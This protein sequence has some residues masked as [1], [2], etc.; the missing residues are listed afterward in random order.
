[1][2]KV[3]GEDLDFVFT[4]LRKKGCRRVIVDGKSVDIAAQFELDESAVQHMDAVVDRFVVDRKHEKAIKAG[5]AAAL[6]VGDG[7]IQV[8]VLAG[9]SKADADRFYRGLS[10]ATHHLV[11][12]EIG[13]SYFVF[14]DP[15]SACRT[16][17]GLG[18]DKV[19]HPELLDSRS[20]AQHPRR[21]LREGGVQVQPRHVGRPRDVQPVEEPRLLARHAVEGSEGARQAGRALRHRPEEGRA[22]LA[23]RGQGQARRSRRQGSRL[24]RHRPAHRALLPA[25]SPARRG[26]LADGGVARQGDGRAHLPGLQGRPAAR[27][28]SAV[29]DRGEDTSTRSGS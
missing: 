4:E 3:Y 6:L 10:S 9:A 28:A 26:Q 20:A 29:H 23:A 19:T 21:L 27:D 17:G 11:Y 25:L 8:H 12:G 2:F 14:N 24:Q 7:L 13:P 1:M 18:V 15:E 16:C 5:I 22:D